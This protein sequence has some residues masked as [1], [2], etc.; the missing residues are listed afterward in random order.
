M[1]SDASGLMRISEDFKVMEQTWFNFRD[2]NFPG[3]HFV[4]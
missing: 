3:S 4:T 2:W 1:E